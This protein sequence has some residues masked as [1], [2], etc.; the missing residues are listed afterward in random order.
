MRNGINSKD[1]D[2]AGFEFVQNVSLTHISTY[3]LRMNPRCVRKGSFQW[4][5][6]GLR[7]ELFNRPQLP[8]HRT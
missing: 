7:M 2:G 1:G 8:G 6:S 4:K 5:Y 3:K